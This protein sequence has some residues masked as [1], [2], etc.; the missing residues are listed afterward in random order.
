MK[1][2]L[3]TALLIVFAYSASE[4]QDL[5]YKN[6]KFKHRKGFVLV[7]KKETFKLK[8]SVGYFYVYPLKSDEELMYFYYNQNETPSYLD[9]DYVKVFFTKSEKV[10]ESKSHYRVLMA[11]LINEH[12]FDSDYNLVEENIDKFIKKYDENISNRTI[13]N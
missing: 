1:N 10:M 6:I 7:D 11:Q 5:T 2:I 4:A 12:V 8:Y 3:A 9:D 13:R